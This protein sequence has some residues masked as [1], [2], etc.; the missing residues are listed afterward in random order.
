MVSLQ[1]MIILMLHPTQ[2]GARDLLQIAFSSGAGAGLLRLSKAEQLKLPGFSYR[3]CLLVCWGMRCKAGNP[4][5]SRGF[6]RFYAG[7]PTSLQSHGSSDIVLL[8]TWWV[9]SSKTNRSTR[10]T[11]VP[12]GD[13]RPSRAP[14]SPWQDTFGT[15]V[16]K[17]PFSWKVGPSCSAHH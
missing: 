5:N 16:T 17:N 14:W 13:D 2:A 9:A 10:K 11:I 8:Q 7:L 1:W 4:H 6:W 12:A 15:F 3:V